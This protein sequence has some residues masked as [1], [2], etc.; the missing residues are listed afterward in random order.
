DALFR[1][2]IAAFPSAEILKDTG[3]GYFASFA[4]TSDAVRFALRFQHELAQMG[5]AP[6]SAPPP[7]QALRVRVGVHVGE[8]AQMEPEQ[9]G[10]PKIVGLAADVVARVTQLAIG[11]QVLLTRF[12][13]NEARQFISS[14]PAADGSADGP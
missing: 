12:A 3:D 6:S 5:G 9:S 13:F 1:R 8:V 7:P 14:L 11:G 4:T 2:S 10:K